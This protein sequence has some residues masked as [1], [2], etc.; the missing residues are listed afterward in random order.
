MCQSKKL[1]LPT[2][3]AAGKIVLATANGNTFM[4]RDS[5][6]V[7][8]IKKSLLLV[9]MLTRFG[10]VVKFV[11]DKCIVYYLSYGDIIVASSS[12]LHG[13]YKLNYYDKC[14]EDLACVVSYLQVLSYAKLWHALFGQLNFAS[15]LQF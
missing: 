11:D 6:Y 5:L 3:E 2:V 15:L 9:S 13:L 4:L 7:S 8:G 10:L 14:M 12:L 1:L